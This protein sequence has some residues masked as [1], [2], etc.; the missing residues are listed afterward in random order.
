MTFILQAKNPPANPVRFLPDLGRGLLFDFDARTIDDAEDGEPVSAW[1]SARGDATGIKTLVAADS[2]PTYKADA[3]NGLPALRFGKS[4]GDDTMTAVGDTD[5]PDFTVS[6]L[7]RFDEIGAFINTNGTQVLNGTSSGRYL[8][9]RPSSGGALYVGAGQSGIS[10]GSVLS[11]TETA[12]HLLTYSF[13]NTEGGTLRRKLDARPIASST[14]HT[15]TGTSGILRHLRI[16]APGALSATEIARFRGSSR[17]W[18]DDEFE[19]WHAKALAEY[20]L[21]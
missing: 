14:G 18:R 12:W 10:M 9:I 20:G 17:I 1:E 19:A 15:S 4:A 11:G 13:S 8:V 16:G 21:A 6:M 7:F 3:I 5:Y 2:P